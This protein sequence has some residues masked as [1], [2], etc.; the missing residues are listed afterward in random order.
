MHEKSWGDWDE[1]VVLTLTPHWLSCTGIKGTVTLVGT[2][3][4]N[5]QIL[6]PYLFL[7][8]VHLSE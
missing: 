2:W 8:R 1:M 4:H 3:I 7:I 5:P 6:A